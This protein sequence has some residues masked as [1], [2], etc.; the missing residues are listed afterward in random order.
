VDGD[1]VPIIL[2]AFGKD[3]TTLRNQRSSNASGPRGFVFETIQDATQSYFAIQ[4]G[5]GAVQHFASGA[6]AQSGIQ[7]LAAGDI[8]GSDRRSDEPGAHSTCVLVERT[9]EEIR[10][11]VEAHGRG[12][13][14]GLHG[15]F[16]AAV[17]DPRD[18]V[19]T[20]CRDRSGVK[21]F[22]YI[23]A[24]VSGVTVAY[25]TSLRALAALVPRPTLSTEAVAS[26]LSNGFVM[27][28]L[29]MLAGAR[30]LLPGQSI[31]FRLDGTILESA[32]HRIPIGVARATGQAESRPE[33]AVRARLV[34]SISRLLPRDRNCGLLLSG[35]VDSSTVAAVIRRDLGTELNTFSLV[36]D[37]TE[38]SES[39][40]SRAVAGKLGT[41]H[42]E[43]LLEERKFI[44]ALDDALQSL[45]QPTT[46]AINGYYISKE[47]K[48]AG[49]DVCFGGIGSDEL[50]G[51]HDC[52]KR[53]PKALRGLKAYHALPSFLRSAVRGLA[54]TVLRSG[55]YF[56][57]SAGVRGKLVS[58]LDQQP[59]VL[60]VYLLSRRVLLPELAARLVRGE[61][62]AHAT[63]VPDE[64]ELYL[65]ALVEESRDIRERLS[66]YEQVFY[67]CNQLL[68]DLE[69]VSTSLGVQFRLPFVDQ[70]LV[71]TVGRVAP[72]ERFRGPLAKQL[73]IDSVKDI[74]PTD[75][76]IRPKLGFVLPIGR[77]LAGELASRLDVLIEDS[78]FVRSVGLDP[79]MLRRVCQDCRD[80]GG[81][82]F[83]TRLWSVFVLLDWCKRTQLAVS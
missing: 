54:P 49:F 5:A 62:A 73:L 75:A 40:Y 55:N 77:W 83:Y 8:C 15:T 36:F 29:T 18:G 3:L 28:P 59:D 76:Y 2:G 20:L 64:L 10:A 21:P 82:I 34:E 7:V 61:T 70:T 44:D 46:D 48:L 38:L 19:L 12:A 37:D 47:C 65:T 33:A 11:R 74:L 26:Y 35:G 68:R 72:D 63:A 16:A 66:V 80:S 79:D 56:M 41:R 17:H 53:V 25:S 57:P 1:P 9:A 22:Y 30:A 43:V 45:D 42:H 14:A 27:E 58:L 4:A 69:G 39:K 24:P 60:S 13:L 52:F 31:T 78:E 67:L 50:F 81:G 32:V 23:L 6:G 71:E 51:G